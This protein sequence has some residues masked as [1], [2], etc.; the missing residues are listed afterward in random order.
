MAAIDY[1]FWQQSYITLNN[2]SDG[3]YANKLIIKNIAYCRMKIMMLRI[4]THLT[5]KLIII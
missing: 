1:R 3:L 2:S 5:K 4:D